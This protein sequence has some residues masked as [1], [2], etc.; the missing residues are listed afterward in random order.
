M[1]AG[2]NVIDYGVDWALQSFIDCIVMRPLATQ[3]PSF[4]KPKLSSHVTGPLRYSSKG[5]IILDCRALTGSP[6]AG[7]RP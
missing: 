7:E 3:S 4:G 5:A 2:S 6:L 1:R